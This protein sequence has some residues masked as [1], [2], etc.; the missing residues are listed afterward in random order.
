MVLNVDHFLAG[1]NPHLGRFKGLHM[2]P[3]K[4]KVKWWVIF[5]KYKGHFRPKV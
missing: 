4:N 3:A 2:T 5:S 1:Q